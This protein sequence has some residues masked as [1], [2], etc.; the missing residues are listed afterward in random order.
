MGLNEVFTLAQSSQNSCSLGSLGALPQVCAALTSAK[1]SGTSS[2]PLDT[3]ACPL[4]PSPQVPAAALALG[5]G[6]QCALLDPISLCH[7][8][9]L[10]QVQSWVV[11]VYLGNFPSLGIEA[12]HFLFFFTPENSSLIYF[13]NGC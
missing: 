11:K 12:L 2:T 6:I 4:V 10:P 9:R 13:V 5:S 1:D 8:R 7:G 3:L